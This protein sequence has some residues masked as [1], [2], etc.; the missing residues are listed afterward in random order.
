MQGAL[1]VSITFLEV[2]SYAL[3]VKGKG[4][5]VSTSRPVVGVVLKGHTFNTNPIVNKYHW[6]LSPYALNGDLRWPSV[7]GYFARKFFVRKGKE[8]IRWGFNSHKR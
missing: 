1:K 7:S 2:L 5:I 6:K 4:M 3:T 8:R